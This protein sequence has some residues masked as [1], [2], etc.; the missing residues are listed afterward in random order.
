MGDGPVLGGVPRGNKAFKVVVQGG[1][2]K[3]IVLP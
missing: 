1:G 3:N 2:K